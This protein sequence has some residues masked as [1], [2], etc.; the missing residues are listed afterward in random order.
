MPDITN[1]EYEFTPKPADPMPPVSRHEFKRKFY[2]CYKGGKKHHHFL[3]GCRRQC[4]RKADA[5]E[6]IPKRDRE[7]IEDGDGR[8]IFWGLLADEEIQALR[9]VIYNVILLAGP[10][11]FWILWLKM[12]H[13]GDLQNASV[14]VTIALS[15]FAML[16]SFWMLLRKR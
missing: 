9:V 1:P 5:L 11:A 16:S 15:S 12:G 4:R 2:S 6:R 10:I 8:E 3:R 14:P 7:I 13:P